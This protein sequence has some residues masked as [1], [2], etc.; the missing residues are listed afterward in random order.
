VRFE[1]NLFAHPKTQNSTKAVSMEGLQKFEPPPK[2]GVDVSI[3]V[4]VKLQAVRNA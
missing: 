1:V 3:F 4:D 2:E